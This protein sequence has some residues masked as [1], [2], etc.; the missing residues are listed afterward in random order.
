[1][2]LRL[3]YQMFLQLL[4][5]IVLRARSDRRKEI[6]ILVSAP[7]ASL[8]FDGARRGGGRSGAPR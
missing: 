4:G 5:W 7:P 2:A 3:I 6:D 8:C 1:M